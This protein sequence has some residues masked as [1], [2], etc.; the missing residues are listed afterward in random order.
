MLITAVGIIIL[1]D[2]FFQIHMS[3]AAIAAKVTLKISS[4][5]FEHEGHI[6]EKYTCDGENVSPPLL[7]NGIPD[8]AVSLV[9]I[10]E[11]PDA[12]GN[13]FDHWVV[14]NIPPV[15]TIEEGG[16][17]GM[18][19]KNSEGKNAYM[20]PCPP[21]GTHRYFFKVYALDTVLDIDDDSD[22][23]I[24][25]QALL[26]HVLAYGELMGMYKNKNDK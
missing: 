22:K 9:L 19:G 13:I 18:V 14:W 25:E 24:I 26:N 5:V 20:G 23:K 4:P 11:D 10:I 15:E 21:S 7:I 17:P 12:P 2:I 3:T 16:L 6:P 8:E 1:D